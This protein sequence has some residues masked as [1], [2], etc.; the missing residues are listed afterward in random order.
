MRVFIIKPGKSEK[1]KNVKRESRIENAKC[2][3]YK[4][5]EFYLHAIC[6]TLAQ[7]AENAESENLFACAHK[8]FMDSIRFWRS[9]RRLFKPL[10]HSL[11]LSSSPSLCFCRYS[12]LTPPTTNWFP[13]KGVTIADGSSH[14]NQFICN[15]ELE[16]LNVH[17]SGQYRC[18]VSGDAPEFKLIDKSANMTV[19]GR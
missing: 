13:V 4:S 5:M 1:R 11:S 9:T 12:P 7:N 6:A 15:V 8:Y 16:K 19:G 14:C 17:S 2:G 10:T 3:G 18:E